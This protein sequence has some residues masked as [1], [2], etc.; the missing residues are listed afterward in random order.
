MLEA[1]LD[2]ELG[3]SKYDYSTKESDNSLKKMKF[4]IVPV[5]NH[6]AFF[7]VRERD[8][9]VFIYAVVDSRRDYS[10]IIF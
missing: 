5:E 4:R 2:T 9:T 1:E 7:K 8:Q 3:Y 10:N 6:L